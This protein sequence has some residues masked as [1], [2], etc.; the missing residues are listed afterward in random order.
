MLCVK[1]YRM[2]TKPEVIGELRLDGKRVTTAKAKDEQDAKLLKRLLERPAIQ[3][4]GLA[5]DVFAK[6]DPALFLRLLCETYRSHYSGRAKPRPPDVVAQDGNASAWVKQ[7]TKNALLCWEVMPRRRFV[8]TFCNALLRPLGIAP[9]ASMI[10]V[11]WMI[12]S[13]I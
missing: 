6:D 10:A 13:Q 8:A 2:Q 12:Q 11:L 4:V 9:A 1:I 7:R 5:N 3:R